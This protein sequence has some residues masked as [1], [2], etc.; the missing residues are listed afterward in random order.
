MGKDLQ[1]KI[2]HSKENE[3]TDYDTLA[4]AAILANPSAESLG[5]AKDWI[6]LARIEFRRQTMSNVEGS[7]FSKD[8]IDLTESLYF[9]AMRDLDSARN[10][11]GE[12]YN[13]M[14]L[15]RRQHTSHALRAIISLS[16]WEPPKNALETPS[17]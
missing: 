8:T 1:K 17:G 6:G 4:R 9:I 2:K 5:L 12:I 10:L 15:D 13:A 7:L 14:P 16:G 11:C 3:P